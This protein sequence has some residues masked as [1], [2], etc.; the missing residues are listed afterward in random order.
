MNSKINLKEIKKNF[1][2]HHVKINEN[3]DSEDIYFCK[4]GKK[5]TNDTNIAK[6]DEITL[7]NNVNGKNYYDNLDVLSRFDEGISVVCP[8]CK[9]NYFKA[10]NSQIVKPSNTD[11]Y[12]YFDFKIEGNRVYL[13]QNKLKS[14]CTDKSKY[15]NLK[16]T[17]SYLCVD[18]ETKKLFFK[19]YDN[20]KE[21]EFSL[22]NLLRV[23]QY[24]YEN[25]NLSVIDNLIDVHRFLSELANIVVDSKNMDIVEGLMSQMIGKPGMDILMKVNTIF[26][27]IIIYSNLSTIALTKG[28]VFL[29]DMLSN[30]KLPN[31]STL[32]ENNVTSPLKIFNFLVTLENE[33][34]QEEIDLEKGENSKFIYTSKNGDGKKMELNF[35]LERFGFKNENLVDISEGSINVRED[36]KNKSVSKYIFNKIEKFNDYKNLIKFT[37]FIS[38]E[39]LINLVIK[40]DI[41]YIIKLYN[42]IEFRSDINSETLKQFIPLTLDYIK[43]QSLT[44][45]TN[46][47]DIGIVQRFEKI[48][49]SMVNNDSN[50]LV[51]E[52]KEVK[53]NYSLISSYSFNI[54]DDCSRILEE[55]K[56]DKN[57]EFNKIK[58]QSELIEYH[59]KL[60]EHYNMLSDKEKFE[61]FKKFAE[62]FSFLEEYDE[63]LKVKLLSTPAMVLK[64]AEEMKNCAG[65]Y[66]TRISQGKY[67]ILMLEDKR[68]D[69]KESDTKFMLGLNLSSSTGLE[70]DQ[71]KTVCNRLG[72][73]RQKEM[74]MKYLEDKDISYREKSDLRVDTMRL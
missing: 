65:S 15:V 70:F 8:K 14:N 40:Y 5:I 37:K 26:F 20:K 44:R 60:V 4:C 9:T 55:L 38:Y 63:N 11:F 6:K 39:E 19:N 41:D 27:G 34:I 58:K 17:V 22:D 71:L 47:Y 48:E 30:C 67:L 51:T 62:K 24:F 50:T 69:R 13:Y 36:I 61:K 29:Y 35:D 21:T 31:I 45:H 74:V 23:V 66:V 53:F 68:P 43:E 3:G 7:E 32:T 33:S 42:K 72:S 28:T 10:Q 18:K 59:D 64:A 52:D 1:C 56:W 73:N 46:K 12:A 2:F 25:H 16:E 57:K 49:D 54:Y